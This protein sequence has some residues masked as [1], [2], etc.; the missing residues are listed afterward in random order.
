MITFLTYLISFVVLI[1]VITIIHESGHFFAARICKVKIL[2]FSIGMG[3]SI[4]QK[5][6]KHQTNY[7]LRILPIGGFV[8]ML[9]EGNDS[10]ERDSFQSKPY[11][12]RLFIVLA[13]PMANFILAFIIFAGLNLYGIQEIS[14]DIG[15]VKKD[16]LAHNAGIKSGTTIISIDDSDV[17]TRMEVQSALLRRLGETGIINIETSDFQGIT[18]SH[19]IYISDWLIGQEPNDLMKD[20]G[21]YLPSEIIIAQLTEN[22]PAANSGL[23]IGDKINAIDLNEIQSWEDLKVFINSSQGKEILVSISRNNSNFDYVVQPEF[24]QS[25]EAQWLIGIAANLKILPSSIM[26]K[27][28]GFF[29]GSIK[30]LKDTYSKSAESIIFLKKM[31]QGLISPRNL[32]GPVMIGQYAGDS[33]KYGGLFSFL[34]LMA[35]ISIGLGIINLLPIPVLDGG[36]A[37]MMTLEKIKGS[38]LSEN[39]VG[40]THR[41]GIAFIVCL[42]IFTFFNDLSRIF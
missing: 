7:N 11:Y 32:G 25:S 35:L 17:E 31:V 30:A 10:S 27:R 28:Y 37:V 1:S 39:F 26:K 38:P 9:G 18:S 33:I 36:Q 41:L 12:Q 19:Q 29:E 34:M 13:G 15:Q 2:D 21:M 24:N 4:F 14:S 5:E 20:L 3:P 22:G 40:I 16:S 23:K 6:D 8:Q 42:M